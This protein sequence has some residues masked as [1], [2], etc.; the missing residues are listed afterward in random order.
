MRAVI[1]RVS[2][3]KVEVDGDIIGKIG[4]GFLV[5]IGVRKDDTEEDVRYLADKVLG[6]RIFEDEAGKMNLSITDVKGEILTVSQFTLYGDSRKGRRPSFDE[7]APLD[8][9]EKLYELFVEEIRKSG[10]KVETGKFRALM[11]V[12]LI[13]SGPVTILLDSKKL[14]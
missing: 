10:I 7:A 11:D 6:L 12:H 9:A 5:L 4:E 14:F 13:N 8:V 2:E 1:Q 3:A